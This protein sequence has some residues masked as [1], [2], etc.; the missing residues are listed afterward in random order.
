MDGTCILNEG[1]GRT[2]RNK[3]E[4]KGSLGRSG[5]HGN[6]LK[7]ILTK[8]DVWLRIGLIWLRI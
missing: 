5:V 6:V 8:Q 4:W 1:R 2:M 3:P 7:L